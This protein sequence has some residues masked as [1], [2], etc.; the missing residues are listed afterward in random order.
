MTDLVNSVDDTF[1]YLCRLCAIKSTTGVAIFSEEGMWR[2]VPKKIRDCLHFT[3]NK[4]FFQIY[5]KVLY[6]T[7]S[8]PFSLQIDQSDKYPKSICVDCIYK[9]DMHYEFLIKCLES[10]TFL[11]S[12][13]AELLKHELYDSVYIIKNELQRRDF[14][15]LELGELPDQSSIQELEHLV[16]E[17]NIHADSSDI[18]QIIQYHDGEVNLCSNN[19]LHVSLLCFL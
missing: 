1:Y 13:S 6:C 16:D 2:E 9:L 7:N 11:A 15:I 18:T 8:S 10:Q 19:L 3:V 17:A 14:E 5:M 4:H 12:L